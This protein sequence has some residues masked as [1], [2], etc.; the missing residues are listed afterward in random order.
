MITKWKLAVVAVVATM[1]LATPAFA[2]SLDPS[3]GTGNVLPFSYVPDGQGHSGYAV[4]QREQIAVHQRGNERI[5]RRQNGLN[6]YAMV[7]STTSR[8]FDSSAPAAT[9][10]GSLGYNQNLY[11]Y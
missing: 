8:S 6:A 7:P 9:G 10:G 3:A 2:Q 4:Q 1:S 5:A 11:N